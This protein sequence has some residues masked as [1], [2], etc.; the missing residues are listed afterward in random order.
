MKYICKSLFL[1][2]IMLCSGTW[3]W[4]QEEVMLIEIRSTVMS[5]DGIPLSGARVS[6]ESDRVF[7]TTD[8]FG[9]FEI[10]IRPNATIEILADG[11]I[12][13]YIQASDIGSEIAMKLVQDDR[14]NVAMRQVNRDK[15]LG[16]VSYVDVTELMNVNYFV[17][18]LD[19][20]A[21]F[22]SGFHGNIWGNNGFLVLV[23]G[24]PRD[25]SS[26]VATE[27]DQISF[28][29]GAAAVALYGSRA[30]KGVILITTKRGVAGENQVNVRVNS[31]IHAPKRIAK[32]LGSAEYMTLYNEARVNDGLSPL[33][34]QEDIYN[35]GSG[36]N[37]YRYPDLDFLSS[38]Y[39]QRVYSAQDAT[40][41]IAGGND[42]ARYYTNIGYWGQGSLLNFGEAVNNRNERINIRGNIDAKLNDYI[43]A[44]VD[45]AMIFRN[46]Y[47]TNANFW[48]GHHGLRPHR[49]SPMIPLSMLEPDDLSSQVYFQNSDHIINGQYLLGGNQLEPTNP[50]GDIYAA[51]TNVNTN[52]QFQF[53]IGT[54]ADLRNLTEGLTFNANFGIDYLTSYTL[55]FNHQ[56]ATYR[57]TWTNYAGEELIASLERFGQDA[58][59]RNQNISNSL[60]RQTLMSS[61]QLNYTKQLNEDHHVYGMLSAYGFLITT[62]GQY[63]RMGN[64]NLGLLLGYEY[65]NKYQVEFNGA[66]P[67]SAKLPEGNRKAISPTLSAGWRLSEEGFMSGASNINNLRLTAS[68]GIINTDLDIDDYYMYVTNVVTRDEGSHW[69]TW[70]DGLS[71]RTGVVMG[72]ENPFFTY[73][74]REEITF[75]LD[76]SFFNN[77]LFFNGN[78]FA[79]RMSGLITKVALEYPS[80]LTSS[81]PNADFL[82]NL[83]YNSDLRTGFDFNLNYREKIGQVNWNFGLVGTYYEVKALRRAEAYEDD[84]QFRSGTPLDGIWGLRSDGFFNSVSE[85]EAAPNQ[86]FGQVRPGDIRYLDQNG[87]GSINV[88]DEVYLGRGGWWG[89]PLTLG[90][91]ITANWKN[92][93]FFALGTGRFGANAMR[94]SPYFRASGESKYSEVVRD[95]WTPETMDTATYPRLTTQNAANNFRT[96]DFWMY[97]TDRF[98]LER[99]Q[100]TYN[101]PAVLTSKLFVKNLDVYL[102]GMNLLTISPYRRIL[103]TN[104][105]GPPQTRFYNLGL[106]ARF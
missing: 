97:S 54:E 76:G 33:W 86:T 20:M 28:L 44:K 2:V 104:F 81:W 55:A 105:A 62:S 23:D 41:E 53:N 26:V 64:A 45:A 40:L 95:R 24:L 75:G 13:R 72:A 82:P 61:A 31:G 38:D 63:H 1:V 27:I 98:D 88:R 7:A 60:F 37:L 6:S 35:H 30:A 57:P 48:G 25:A 91:N 56:Y 68:A 94:D 36:I 102:S 46:D 74:K 42:R 93:T 5:E 66:M 21:S 84:Y 8:D 85:I 52:R 103:E 90:L 92:F 32:Y 89:S 70:N 77:K 83:N 87:D 47:G 96:S 29:K 9:K 73:P 67:H 16:G 43:T 58:S 17:N 78:Y 80:Y 3:L 106:N 79:S 10:E 100:I 59:T 22:A 39:L 69:V 11:Y 49:V 18:S 51:G 99:V 14:V 34:T 50:I 15:L 12:A 19:N 71:V 65:K 101:V 4:A